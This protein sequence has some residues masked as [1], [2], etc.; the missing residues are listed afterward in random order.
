VF[1][2]VGEFVRY[3]VKGDVVTRPVV[4]EV[5]DPTFGA[6]T[7]TGWLDPRKV[8]IT[9]PHDEPVT[10][11][12]VKQPAWQPKWFQRFNLACAPLPQLHLTYGNS[13]ALEVGGKPAP[14]HGGSPGLRR[15]AADLYATVS[16]RE[17]RLRN[18]SKREANL[19]RDGTQVVALSRKPLRLRR[20]VRRTY[21]PA[22]DALD[23]TLA[24]AFGYCLRVGAEG[25]VSN[26]NP[27]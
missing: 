26:L 8:T 15:R 3:V 4:V 13:V 27:F 11:T 25:A 9:G 17:Y 16:G 19:E 24:V 23:A 12:V 5:A 2:S 1:D 20:S 14:F 21:A 18:L 7:L 10:L 22:A 6:F